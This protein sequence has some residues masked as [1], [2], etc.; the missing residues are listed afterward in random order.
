[1]LETGSSSPDR[2]GIC[3]LNPSIIINAKLKRQKLGLALLPKSIIRVIPCLLFKCRQRTD[4][5]AG[6]SATIDFRS[7]PSQEQQS[8]KPKSCPVR[9]GVRVSRLAVVRL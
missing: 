7:E 9:P 6:R 8:E 3:S 5:L 1:M 2:Y 4:Q